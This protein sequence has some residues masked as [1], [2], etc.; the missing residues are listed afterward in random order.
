MEKAQLALGA[1]ALP[2]V[3]LRVKSAGSLTEVPLMSNGAVPG[4]VSLTIWSAAAL[5]ITVGGNVRL[6]GASAA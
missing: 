5:W 3:E 2:Q 4:L 1:R 6:T